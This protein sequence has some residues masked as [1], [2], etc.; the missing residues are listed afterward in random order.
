MFDPA[1]FR[2]VQFA[3]DALD[4]ASSTL[5]PLSLALAAMA[6]VD[7]GWGDAA[8]VADLRRDLGDDVF[9]FVAHVEAQVEAQGRREEAL[10]D[11]DMDVVVG[12]PVREAA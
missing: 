11:V 5:D 8:L 3:L 9:E 10:E 6:R 7:E 12:V 2:E 1:R 4:E